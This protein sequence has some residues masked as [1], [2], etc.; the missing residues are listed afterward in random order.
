MKTQWKRTACL[1]SVVLLA[2]I[3]IRTQTVPADEPKGE[4]DTAASSD[5]E[6]KPQPA[7]IQRVAEDVA[8]DRARLLHDVYSATLDTLHHRYFHGDRA[9]VPARAMQDVF[10]ELSEKSQIEARWIAVNLKAM[11]LDHEPET[12]FEKSAA[13]EL[14]AGKAEFEVVRDGFLRRATPIPLGNGCVSCHGGL[15]QKPSKTPKLAGL[16]ISIPIHNK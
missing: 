11:S 8:R 3:A 4:T 15:F 13:T 14:A 5:Q 10:D 2:T 9:V 6:A 12:E 1:F 16:V 7:S